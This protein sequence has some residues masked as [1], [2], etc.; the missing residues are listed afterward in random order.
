MERELPRREGRGKSRKV[1]SANDRNPN[2]SEPRLPYQLLVGL[3]GDLLPQPEGIVH[4]GRQ[5]RNPEVGPA[6]DSAEAAAA[7]P[8][9]GQCGLGEAREGV[10]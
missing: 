3:L 4:D 9:V 6:R 8:E 7:A 2:E 10:I 1:P 5:F